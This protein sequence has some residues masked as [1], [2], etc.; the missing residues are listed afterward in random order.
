MDTGD[1]KKLRE[2]TGLSIMLCK[3]ALELSGGD[4]N[5]A[6]A[7]LKKESAGVAEKKKERVTGS[8]II[9]S[10]VHGEG[11]IGVLAEIRCETDFVARN[12]AFKEFAHN[13]AMHIAALNPHFLSPTDAPKEL[14]EEM[15]G[16][17]KSETDSLN[18]PAD[19]REKIISGKMD[20]FLKERSLL[21]QP[22]IKNQDITVEDYIK[23]TVQKFGENIT[24][25]RFVRFSL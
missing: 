18:K 15:L 9:A 22:Y 3:K 25:A 17:F 10:Y 23:E 24:I 11:R 13:L 20:A 6:F 21:S 12:D 14:K 2:E 16:V 8:G 7:F 4:F 1:V 5:K 19:I